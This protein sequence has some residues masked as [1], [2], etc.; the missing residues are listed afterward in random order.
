MRPSEVAICRQ[1]QARRRCVSKLDMAA[2]SGLYRKYTLHWLVCK[3]VSGRRKASMR[4]EARR[5]CRQYELVLSELEAFGLKQL[6]V[7]LLLES[8]FHMVPTSDVQ[9]L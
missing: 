4:E 2:A 1:H 9:Y 3:A 8:A 7:Q 5:D 6:F